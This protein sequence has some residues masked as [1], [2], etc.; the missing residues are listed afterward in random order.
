MSF[1]SFM[2][3]VSSGGGVALAAMFSLVM[4]AQSIAQTEQDYMS[5]DGK[6]VLITGST[7]GMGREVAMR[8]GAL[9]AHVIVHGRSAARGAEVVAEINAGPGTAEFYQADLAN[10]DEVRELAARVVLNHQQLH[11]LINNAGIGSGFA[12]G[13]RTVSTDGYEMI[14]QVN[15][16]AHYLLTDLLLPVIKASAPARIVNVASGAQ[17]PINFEDIMLEQ[18]FEGRT[19]YAQ[20]KLAQI[21]HTFHIAEQ[22]EGTGVTFTTLHPATM[23]DTTMVAMSGRPAMST[24]DEGA[25][26]L[27]NLA[28]SPAMEGR[29]GLYFNGLNETRASDQ[30]YDRAARV[31]LDRM[32]RELAGLP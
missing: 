17:A 1:I 29:T 27:M 18:A 15:Y 25:T 31:R 19:A 10:L 14:F 9:G 4:V 13:R 7:D 23:M 3:K 8:L 6:T 24:V 20:S 26:A 32:S 11:L 21:L 5:M 30:A 2:K 28:A 12:D 22:L 16:L